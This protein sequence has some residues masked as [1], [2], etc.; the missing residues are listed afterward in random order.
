MQS[1]EGRENKRV[2][3]TLE[4]Y[5]DVLLRM[6]SIVRDGA[7]A[8]EEHEAFPETTSLH[9]IGLVAVAIWGENLTFSL[10]PLKME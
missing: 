6:F 1:L 10:I 7:V 5:Y 4:C 9:R 2:K 8:V 3:E